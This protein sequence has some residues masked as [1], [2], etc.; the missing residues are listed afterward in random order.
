MVNSLWYQDIAEQAHSLYSQ[1][2]KEEEKSM[3]KILNRVEKIKRS[4]SQSNSPTNSQYLQQNN[5]SYDSPNKNGK[6]CNNRDDISFSSPTLSDEMVIH[7]MRSSQNGFYHYD[8]NNIRKL[9]KFLKQKSSSKKHKNGKTKRRTSSSTNIFN[10]IR[11][12]LNEEIYHSLFLIVFNVQILLF[13]KMGTIFSLIAE[14]LR[15]NL[16]AIIF[17]YIGTLIAFFLFCWQHAF[18]S[19]E[20]KWIMEGKQLKHRIKYF[21]ERVP[22]FSGFGAPLTLMVLLAPQFIST[23]IYAL[24]FPLFIIQ[25]IESHPIYVTN[26]KISFWGITIISAKRDNT[27]DSKVMYKPLRFPVFATTKWLNYLIVWFCGNHFCCVRSILL[28]LQ[29]CGKIFGI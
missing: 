2:R 16:I 24:T 13:A 12:T 15:Y 17:D 26:E 9:P 14:S 11:N 7:N 28:F 10:S 4:K 29:K 20:Y 22:Y 25:A 6:Y 21:E 1:S 23:G 27:N 8:E 19:F 18:L 5:Y 3:T